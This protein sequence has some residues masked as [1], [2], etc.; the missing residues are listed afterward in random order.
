[1]VWGV[2]TETGCRFSRYDARIP[3]RPHYRRT[4]QL[5]ANDKCELV[6]TKRK[7]TVAVQSRR[8]IL[9]STRPYFSMPNRPQVPVGS[10][11]QP[12][13]P[14]FK[15][16][17]YRDP[18]SEKMRRVDWDWAFVQGEAFD[19]WASPYEPGGSVYNE[20]TFWYW[21]ETQSSYVYSAGGT[22]TDYGHHWDPCID[23]LGEGADPAFYKTMGMWAFQ[24]FYSNLQVIVLGYSDGSSEC[25]YH[26]DTNTMI[27][28]G[29]TYSCTA[30]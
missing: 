5:K 22:C 11:R 30:V 7:E 2:P 24:G 17:L 25:K 4:I 27:G 10:R 28:A 20:M 15:A 13:N 14:R 23:P 19:F 6:V 9:T 12:A 1:M 16:L 29:S 21:P 26:E 8:A 18:L 3:T